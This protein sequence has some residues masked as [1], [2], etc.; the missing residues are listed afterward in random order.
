MG[1]GSRRRRVYLLAL[2]GGGSGTGTGC[3]PTM[4]GRT[5]RGGSMGGAVVHF[6]R[7]RLD[8]ETRGSGTV[9]RPTRY[10]ATLGVLRAIRSSV[11][12]VPARIG[13][14]SAIS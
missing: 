1:R 14:R 13:F 5:D 9:G 3:G 11:G 12:G 6:A 2:D 10:L 7:L 8:G 4:D